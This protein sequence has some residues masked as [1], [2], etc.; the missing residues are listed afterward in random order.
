MPSGSTSTWKFAGGAPP[1]PAPRNRSRPD[2]GAADAHGGDRGVDLHVAVLGGLRRRRS[3]IVPCTRLISD[4][5]FDPSG[6]RSIRS[7][8]SWRSTPRPNTVPSMKVMPSV[9]SD[10]GLDHVAFVDVVAI[11]QNDRNAVADRGRVA[12]QLGDMADHLGD[13]RRCRR[14]AQTGCAGQRVDDVAGEMGAIGRSQRCPLL[15]LEVVLQDQ[16]AVVGGQESRS[17]P[18]RLKSPVKSRWAS[19][20]IM[21][22]E[23]ACVETLSTWSAPLR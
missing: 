14:P 8:P 5:L 13:A 17:T 21:A 3:E 15:A 7:A 4:E 1:S 11:V 20:T 16:F 10:A 23:G 9:E 12:D 2:R 22:S 19:G 6:R 18:D